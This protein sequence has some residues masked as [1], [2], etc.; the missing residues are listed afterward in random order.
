MSKVIYHPEAEAELIDAAG[1]YDKRVPGLGADFL[2]EVD[3]AVQAIIKY[4]RRWL[5]IDGE[6][7]RYLVKR[8]PYAIVYRP[9][10][11]R[12]RVLAIKHNRREPNYWKRRK[13]TV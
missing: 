4:P 13:D 5:V 10:K 7:R 12:I 2:H 6:F 9:E 1:F 11:A 3:S 8:F